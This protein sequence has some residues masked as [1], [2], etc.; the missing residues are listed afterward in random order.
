MKS[1]MGRE[2]PIQ[3]CSLSTAS[4]RCSTGRGPITANFQSRGGW[5]GEGDPSATGAPDHPP[6]LRLPCTTLATG[7][8]RAQDHNKNQ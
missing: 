2:A 6:L 4:G 3:E 1:A 5:S 8:S 7:R